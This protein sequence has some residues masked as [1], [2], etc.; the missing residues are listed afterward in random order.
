M[1]ETMFWADYTKKDDKLMLMS[2]ILYLYMSNYMLIVIFNTN[3][4]VHVLNA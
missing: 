4:N 3:A 1:F 2:K